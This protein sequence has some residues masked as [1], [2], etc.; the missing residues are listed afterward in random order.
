M[1]WRGRGLIATVLVAAVVLVGAGGTGLAQDRD[2]AVEPYP[3]VGNMALARQ[4]WFLNCQGCHKPDASGSPLG[5]PNMN[6]V[7][8]R[9]LSVEGGRAY[10]SSVPGVANAPISDKRA[11]EVLNWTLYRYDRDNIPDDF[12]PYTADEV[13]IF[14]SRNLVTQAAAV[15]RKLLEAMP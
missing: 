13:A 7:I 3:G 9:F 10:L 11:A 2:L 14:R 15:R 1:M 8:A 12:V 6:G 5:A 4:D